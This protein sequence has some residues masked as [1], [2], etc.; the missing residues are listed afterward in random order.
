MLSIVDCEWS[1]YTEWSDCSKS[2]G[3]GTRISNRTIL[4][5]AIDG[6]QECKGEALKIESCNDQ[7]CPGIKKDKG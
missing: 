4:K 3:G 1:P 7:L 5:N 2:C 6:G